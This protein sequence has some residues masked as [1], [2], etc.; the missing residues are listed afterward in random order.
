VEDLQPSP[1]PST[2][3]SATMAPRACQRQAAS[4]QRH[5]DAAGAHLAK[6]GRPRHPGITDE[7]PHH[8]HLRS[9]HT[10]S[11]GYVAVLWI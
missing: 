10:K 5:L 6:P 1:R 7:L 3:N 4:R 8:C 9:H 11:P 2:A